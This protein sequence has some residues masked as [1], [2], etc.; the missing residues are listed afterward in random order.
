M[1]IIISSSY[2]KLF[3]LLKELG[4]S[5]AKKAVRRALK[6]AITGVSTTASRD[7]RAQK[8]IHLGA[9]AF[10]SRFQTELNT[11]PSVPISS[12]FAAIT[13]S[14]KAENLARFYAKRYVAGRSNSIMAQ[15]KF[16][17]WKGVKLYGVK[18]NSLGQQDLTQN[19]FLLDNGKGK[20]KVILSRTTNA[21]FPLKKLKGPSIAEILQHS[22]ELKK[23]RAVGAE[24]YEKELRAN[25]KYFA[26][27][28]VAKASS[29]K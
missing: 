27:Q 8:L 7:M 17:G 19:A 10:K 5:A 22:G 2:G 15:D 23:L 9:R 18:V 29:G 28:A 12:M 13:V 4:N 24:R 25:V 1:K 16:G 26:S 6:R 21:R 3:S 11:G 14:G 20:D